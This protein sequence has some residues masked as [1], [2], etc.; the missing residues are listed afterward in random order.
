MVYYIQFGFS[1]L[2]PYEWDQ[3]RRELIRI[4]EILALVERGLAFSREFRAII[5]TREDYPS[6]LRV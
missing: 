1:A 3:V 2:L 6:S 5:R 4:L